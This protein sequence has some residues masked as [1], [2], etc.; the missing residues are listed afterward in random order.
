MYVARQLSQ[1]EMRAQLENTIPTLQPGPMRDWAIRELQRMHQ[2]GVRQPG[3][4]ATQIAQPGVVTGQVADP[5]D[6]DPNQLY[7]EAVKTSLIDAMLKYS[8]GLK[9]GADECLTVAAGDAQGPPS[10]GAV[11]DAST[12]VIRI[13]GADLT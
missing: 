6:P 3:A 12:I 4:S 8:V 5:P 2:Q 9:L 13:K 10:P 7:T 11:D 1:Q